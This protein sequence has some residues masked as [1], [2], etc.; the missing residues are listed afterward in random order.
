[1]TDA[2]VD[3]VRASG[4][5]AIAQ[6]VRFVAKE[7]T[8]FDH[9]VAAFAGPLRVALFADAVEGGRKPIRTPFPDVS[10][11]VVQ[12]IAV[13]RILV[14]G[15]G[16]VETVVDAVVRGKGALPDVAPMLTAG[17]Q[18][19]TPGVGGLLQSAAGRER[20]CGFGGQALAAPARVGASVLPADVNDGVIAESIESR[21][22]PGRVIPARPVHLAPPGRMSDAAGGFEVVR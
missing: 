19:V 22:R 8:S 21:L 2:G 12:P 9:P 10:G 3:G 4:R 14:D 7:R 16:R 18:L 15:R 11:R 17:C 5:H 20:P 1:V 6:T 13:R